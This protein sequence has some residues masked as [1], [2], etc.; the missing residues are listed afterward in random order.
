MLRYVT[1]RLICFCY[2][3]SYNLKD[4]TINR[5]LITVKRNVLS[6][7]DMIPEF[8]KGTRRRLPCTDLLC[9]WQTKKIW[10]FM[11]VDTR[12]FSL[13]ARDISAN[14]VYVV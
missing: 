2:S 11:I 12:T 10:T 3:Y 14:K 6:I 7:Q 8:Q 4:N 1:L 9:E 13:M 5:L